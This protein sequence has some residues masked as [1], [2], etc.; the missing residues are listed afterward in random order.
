MRIKPSRGD[1]GVDIYV[2]GDA[3][4]IV[5]QVKSFTGELTS[6]HKRQ[7]TNSWDEFRD[8][9]AERNLNVVA[10]YAVRPENPTWNNIQWL[11]TLTAGAG[12]PC[13][14]QGLDFLE[15]LA[16][17]YQDVID[18]YLR[19]G[20]ERLEQTIREFL[21]LAGAVKES[22]SGDRALEPS[23]ALAAL[24]SLHQALNRFDPHYRFDF[25]V[26]TAPESEEFPPIPEAERL[27]AAVI[28]RIGSR[29]IVIKIFARFREATLERPVPGSLEIEAAAGSPEAVSLQD[30]IEY[31]TPT[32]VLTAKSVTVDLPG[33]FGG[34]F[35]DVGIR[36]GPPQS[37]EAIP[38]DL[39][40]HILDSLDNDTELASADIMMEPATTG[41]TGSGAVRAAGRERYGVFKI[42]LR[43]NPATK[44]MNLSI[45]NQQI[46]GTSPADVLP[47]LQVL[48]VIQTVR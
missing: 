31:G 34:E 1:H 43:L 11:E 19:D 47:G 25:S 6:S 32:D 28:H 15:G 30:F 42:E 40:L 37:P 17:K 22:E 26:E 4:W 8:F 12:F 20:K 35:H 36:I 45:T 24:E 46:M 38:F 41:V 3:G 27:V 2:P 18:Y 48:R 23:G 21:T 10:W 7:I 13:A 5:Y 9:V 39:Q 14:W 16:A 44:K 29:R 33:G